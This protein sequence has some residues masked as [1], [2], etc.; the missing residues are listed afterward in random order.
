[1]DKDQRYGPASSKGVQGSRAYFINGKTKKLA[2][3]C[4]VFHAKRIG[5]QVGQIGGAKYE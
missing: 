5:G 4:A 1:M 3:S 2:H